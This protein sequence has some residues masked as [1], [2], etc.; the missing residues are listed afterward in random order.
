MYHIL[1][2][3]RCSGC[4]FSNPIFSWKTR[5]V[6]RRSREEICSPC[7]TLKSSA[8]C[9]AGTCMVF[10]VLQLHRIWVNCRKYIEITEWLLKMP[11]YPRSRGM[12]PSELSARDMRVDVVCRYATGEKTWPTTLVSWTDKMERTELLMG[13]QVTG[14]AGCSWLNVWVCN[15]CGQSEG[16]AFGGGWCGSCADSNT[17]PFNGKR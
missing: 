13:S 4:K 1:Y 3:K 5:G 10:L 2:S 8:K 17:I 14:F 15:I 16:M 11:G 7:R 6:V 12:D 9:S